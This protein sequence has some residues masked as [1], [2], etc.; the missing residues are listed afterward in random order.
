MPFGNGQLKKRRTIVGRVGENVA[1]ATDPIDR[2]LGD[3][4]G[5]VRTIRLL[6]VIV[7]D[8]ETT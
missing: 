8:A 3:V 1:C 4:Q 2:F 7:S 6:L 5:K